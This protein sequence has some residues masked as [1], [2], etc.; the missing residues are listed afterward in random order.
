MEKT[1][2]I[3]DDDLN[4]RK[5]LAI[6]IAKNNLGRVVAELD[7]GKYA[8]DEIMFYNPDI[9]LIDLLLPF[10]DGIDIINSSMTKGFK[11]KFIMVSQVEDSEMISK[12][13]ESGIIFFISKPINRIEA[14][15]VIKNV[16]HNIDLE[17][18]LTLIKNA[19]LNTDYEKNKTQEVNLDKQ[20]NKIF[21]SIGIL[22]TV[23]NAELK[24]IILK[25][26]KIKHQDPSSNYQLQKLYEEVIEE[27]NR[28]NNKKLNVK[29]LEQRIR[30]AIQKSLLTIAEL[31]YDDYDNEIF[32]EYSTLL[33][34]FKQV[35]QQ[36]LHIKN[37]AE[38]QGKINI[39][40]FIEGIVSKLI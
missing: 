6:I 21:S 27:E 1:F 28:F 34:D 14:I 31:G 33:F 13:Y 17:N 30:R 29:T 37:P 39:K 32:A 9:V 40:K 35:R 10:Q 36:M 7:S 15:N 8:V 11:G 2:L 38:E 26:I 25:I 18:S 19:V 4:I 3:I 16:S 12:A 5:M 22:G 23:G 24:K 20:I